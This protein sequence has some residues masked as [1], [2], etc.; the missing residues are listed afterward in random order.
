M[1]DKEQRDR[2]ADA[3]EVA[4]L[5]ALDP[6]EYDRQREGAAKALGVRVS[7]LDAMVEEARPKP[8]PEAAT[9]GNGLE[10]DPRDR[11][12][13]YLNGGDLPDTAAE[14]AKRLAEV[15]HLF[16]RGGP[17]RIAFDVQR[18][19]MLAEPLGLHAVVN[20]AH[21]IARPWKYVPRGGELIPQ[22]AT[23]PERVAS[24]Y[25][26]MRGEWGLRPLDGIAASPLL[27]EDGGLRVVDGYDAGTRMWCERMPAIEVP[28]TPNRDDAAAALLRLRLFLRSFAF[29]DAPRVTLPG[30]AVP[31]VDTSKPPG[32][33][34]SAA[35][36]ALV[37]AVCRPS[38][39]LAPGLVVHA[40]SYSGAGTGKGLLVRIICAIAYGL[41]PRAMTA[42]GN[43]DELEK[44]LAAALI[45]AEQVV[46]LD[47]VNGTALRSDMLASAITERPA[48]VRRL[49]ASV[50][51]PLN[52]T[53]F[54]AVTGN[55]LVLS[56]DLARRFVTVELDA[57]MED[58]EAR[59][60]KGDVLRDALDQR[61][62]LLRDVLIIWRW[63]RLAG[64]AIK[65]GRALGSFNDWSRWCRD[66]LLALGCAD[67]ASRIAEA[68]ANDPRR[69][70]IAEVFAAWWERHHDLA[71]KVADL[72]DDVRE[73]ADPAGK[74]RQYL[75]AFVAKLE[76]T[77]AAGFVLTRTRTTGKW[78]PDLYALKPADRP[79]GAENH[80]EHREHRE[81]SAGEPQESAASAPEAHPY[82][83]PYASPY[84]A[85]HGGDH[86]GAGAG[87]NAGVGAHAPYDPYASPGH[88][89]GGGEESGAGW[90]AQL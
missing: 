89:G 43:P 67:P 85:D 88:S 46:F 47:N 61:A 39:R 15:P 34:E 60:F 54:I 44:R 2:A 13:L 82:G 71:V 31:V 53:A 1:S 32:M 20:E 50:T 58:P 6:L 79:T 12:D 70:H 3:A 72:H 84:A 23:L 40:P 7:I 16:D 21:R 22:P 17:A 18:G 42:G 86:R 4:R 64:E 9:C 11:P 63:G 73:V 48:Y 66:P 8:W 78:S 25:L 41:A 35:L 57:G 24:L 77:R 30:E 49:G 19:G 69:K 75:A 26:A 80:R 74:G 81:G 28:E 14:L 45:G 76:G 83:S 38:L 27:A 29:A 55:G 59:D 10:P 33:D 56:E 37:T 87:G 5:A 90:A 65:P 52:P 68:K 62:G 36:V 51:M